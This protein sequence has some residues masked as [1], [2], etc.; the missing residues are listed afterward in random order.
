MTKIELDGLRSLS[1]EAL[2]QLMA[3]FHFN[4]A[5]LDM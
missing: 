1:P 4:W 2:E 3:E 5:V